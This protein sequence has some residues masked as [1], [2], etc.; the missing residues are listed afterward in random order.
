MS[1]KYSKGNSKYPFFIFSFVQRCTLFK[2]Y[3]ILPDFSKVWFLK[4]DLKLV[5]Q[6]SKHLI[7]KI[8]SK[9][10]YFICC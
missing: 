9:G 5:G 7:R 2:G 6:S 1:L 10:E 3:S 8:S 4:I